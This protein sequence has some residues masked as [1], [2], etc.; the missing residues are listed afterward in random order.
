[1]VMNQWKKHQEKVASMRDI[2][3]IGYTKHIM[4][5]DG[6]ITWNVPIERSDLIPESYIAQLKSISQ[7]V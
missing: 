3:K 6:A 4:N 7:E 1:M 5:Q 2:V